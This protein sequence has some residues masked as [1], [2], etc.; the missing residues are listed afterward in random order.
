[1]KQGRDNFEMIKECGLV[2]CTKGVSVRDKR[3]S[4]Y[5]VMTD[6]R[7]GGDARRSA[8]ARARRKKSEDV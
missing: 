1:M 7:D 8:C 5:K 4:L 3:A 2:V 6:E